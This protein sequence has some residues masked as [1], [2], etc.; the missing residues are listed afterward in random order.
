VLFSSTTLDALTRFCVIGSLGGGSGAV[1][2]GG[3]VRVA[4]KQVSHKLFVVV[5]CG[6][7]GRLLA[8]HAG[9]VGG[10]SIIFLTSAWVLQ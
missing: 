5:H 10:C 2:R 7:N 4:V 1:F 9:I 8:D 3:I 6:S